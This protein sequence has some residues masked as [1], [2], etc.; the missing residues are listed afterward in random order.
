MTF[1][2]N[3][4][5]VIISWKSIQFESIQKIFFLIFFENLKKNQKSFGKNLKKKLRF[6]EKIWIFLGKIKKNLNIFGKN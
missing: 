5:L 3:E 4:N 2:E 1:F 6:L